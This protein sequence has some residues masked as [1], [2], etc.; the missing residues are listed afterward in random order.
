[1]ALQKFGSI[2][3]DLDKIAYVQKIP[4]EIKP[5]SAVRGEQVRVRVGFEHG[6]LNLYEDEPGYEEFIKWLDVHVK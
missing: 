5:G 1:M 2:Y 6:E 3:L 4:P